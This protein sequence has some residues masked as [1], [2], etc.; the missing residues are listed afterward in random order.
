MTQAR[1]WVLLRS[2]RRFDL[3]NPTPLD[4]ELS[5]LAEGEARTFRWGGS[6]VWDWPLSVAQ[7]SLLTLEIHRAAAPT[8]LSPALELANLVHDGAEALGVRWDPITPVKPFLGEGFHAMDRAIQR[9]IHLRLGVPP[10]LPVEW[11]K[12]IKDADRRAAAAE[13]L[14]VAGWSPQEIRTTLKIRLAPLVDDPL[15][16]RYGG[17]PWQPWPMRLAE[18]RFLTELERLLRRHCPAN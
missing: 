18:E 13:A 8:G 9:A 7:H 17:A 1:A 10:D 14:H 2:K 5:D 4:W 6:S 11:K 16:R 3:L 12:A 15:V